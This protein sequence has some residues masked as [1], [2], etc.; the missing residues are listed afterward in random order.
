[1]NWKPLA[2]RRT[3]AL[4]GLCLLAVA[5]ILFVTTLAWGWPLPRPAPQP[6]RP[7]T[8]QETTLVVG[9]ML[10]FIAGDLA[11]G[12]LRAT[13]PSS[14]PTKGPKGGRWPPAFVN[15]AISVLF[16]L[17]CLIVATCALVLVVLASKLAGVL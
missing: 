13:P 7:L 12:V 17:G 8:W 16:L 15:L 3:L 5:A 10:L 9:T 6:S 4:I 1:M 11:E 14:T 2:N